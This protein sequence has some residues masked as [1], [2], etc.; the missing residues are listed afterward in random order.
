[1]SSRILQGV[2]F[3]VVLVSG[4]SY[5]AEIAP[6][7][8]LAQAL[9]Y[10]GVL[11]LGAQAAGPALGELIV[12]LSGWSWMFRA[13]FAFGIAGAMVASF[14]PPPAAGARDVEQPLAAD[15]GLD[16]R[17]GIAANALAGFG[18]GAVF[19]FL[20]EFASQR[21]IAYIT[22]FAASYVAAAVFSRLALGHLTD[23]YGYRATTGPTLIGHAVALAAVSQLSAMWQLVPIGLLYGV[24]HGIYYPA[25]QALIVAR[26]AS[27][28]RA[29][30]ASSFAFGGGVGIASFGLGELATV[31][32]YSSIY[33]V[34]SAAGVI[35]AGI[36]LVER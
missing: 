34:A 19:A 11:T 4:P 6:P 17:H 23:R 35:A 14:L 10:A 20:A 3:G 9:G 28:S 33:L 31:V 36:V 25:L 18:F 27:R 22:P 26:S 1:M 5:V 16:A 21:G 29:I 8:R 7:K 2:G 15:G 32:G 13:G 12:E 30:A 24:C